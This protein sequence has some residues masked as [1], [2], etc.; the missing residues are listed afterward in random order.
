MSILQ[1]QFQKCQDVECEAVKTSKQLKAHINAFN[2]RMKPQ[3][4]SIWE[5]NH[6]NSAREGNK[7]HKC[8]I[9]DQNFALKHQLKNHTNTIHEEIKPHNCSICDYSATKGN[10]N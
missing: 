9:C 7:P 10:L 1:C 8:S 5:E 4:C 6:I 3:K 2:E